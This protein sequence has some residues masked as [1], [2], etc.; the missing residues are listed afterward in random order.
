M[1]LRVLYHIYILN[2]TLSEEPLVS[3]ILRVTRRAADQR[4]LRFMTRVWNSV[5]QFRTS[6]A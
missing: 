5:A 1:S 6:N 3:P 4:A 2:S